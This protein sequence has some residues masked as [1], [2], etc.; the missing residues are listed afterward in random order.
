MVSLEFFIDII[1]PIALWLW[2]RLSLW[3]KWIP[4]AFPGGKKR[5]V[6]KADNLTTT[7]GHCQVIWEPSGPPQACS[8][9][10]LPFLNKK[11]NANKIYHFPSHEKLNGGKWSASNSGRFTPGKNDKGWVGPRPCVNTPGE[12]K[13]SCNC[14]DPKLG[15]SSL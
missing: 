1:L 6:R 9:A 10:A 12:V 2:G 11:V 8:G 14:Q 3:Q 13:F 4:G 7:L 5:P 15:P